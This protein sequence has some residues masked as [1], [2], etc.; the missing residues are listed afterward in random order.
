MSEETENTVSNNFTRTYASLQKGLA[1]SE[2]HARHGSFGEKVRNETKYG[3]LGKRLFT[4]PI[5]PTMWF[6]I[7]PS[8]TFCFRSCL[9]Q[10]NSSSRLRSAMVS[11]R[12]TTV[13]LSAF[14]TTCF[15]MI[16][17]ILPIFFVRMQRANTMMFTQLHKCHQD[18]NDIWRQLTQSKLLG[19]TRR[20]YQAP[21]Y[22]AA[23]PPAF[24]S[25][26]CCSCQQGPPGA[27]GSRGQDGRPG[28]DG[29]PGIN[30]RNG[31]DGRYVK[32]EASAEPPCQKC[33]SAPPGPPGHPGHKG[34]RGRAGTPGKNGTP[35]TPGRAGP[36][37]PSGVRGPPG[38]RGTQGPP[39]DS[40]GV[41]NGA[42]QGPPGRTGP[43]GPRG[44]PGTP[45]V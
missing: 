14:S 8:A 16:S 20:Q 39:G 22:E 37:G 44:K 9:E 33:P 25:G 45:G 19:R 34:P 23:G 24:P 3:S 42:P 1:H 41:L 11:A 35:G 31:H 28:K 7:A 6:C 15:F 36:P 40:G 21:G 30:G 43:A 2:E 26:Q 29:Y 10:D 17:A 27:P 18:S 13:L 4:G 12:T 32:A 38:E 5:Y